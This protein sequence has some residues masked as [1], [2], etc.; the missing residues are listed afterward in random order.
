MTD[1]EREHAQGAQAE[2]TIEGVE[3][4]LP[5]YVSN[6][7]RQLASAAMDDLEDEDRSEDRSYYLARWFDAAITAGRRSPAG[8][9]SPAANDLVE[10]L[11][12]P[13]WAHGNIPFESPQLEKEE[14]LA[15]MAEAAAE[16]ERLVGLVENVEQWRS[17]LIERIRSSTWSG[18][19]EIVALIKRHSLTSTVREGK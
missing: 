8:K 13:M 2:A 1:L 18:S 16:I 15:A 10:R 14:N 12:N 6:L 7:A 17:S 3:Q 4:W 9:A 5:R 19:E 11:R